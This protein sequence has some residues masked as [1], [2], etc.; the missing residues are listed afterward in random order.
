MRMTKALMR[1]K[2]TEDEI[3]DEKNEEKTIR[4]EEVPVLGMK[5]FL[6]FTDRK[7]RHRPNYS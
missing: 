4:K 5:T 7:W 2:K 6:R 3:K 1:K